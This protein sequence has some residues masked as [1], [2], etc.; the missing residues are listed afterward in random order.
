[1]LP[2]KLPEKIKI[3]VKGNPLDRKKNWKEVIIDGKIYRRETDTLDTFCLF[4]V[5]LSKILFTKRNNQ[6]FDNNEDIIIGCLCRSVHWWC[7]TCNITS[8]LF[9]VF[10]ESNKLSK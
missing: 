8:T 4:V 9:K 10:H 7:R 3:K 1:M 2:V 6:G 5:V